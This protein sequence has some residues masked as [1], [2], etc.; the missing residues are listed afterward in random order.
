MTA[1]LADRDAAHARAVR[2]QADARKRFSIEAMAA[3]IE[4]VYGRAMVG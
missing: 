2:L 1:V 3:G 4:N